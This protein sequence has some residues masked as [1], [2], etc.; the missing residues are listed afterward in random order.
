MS[1]QHVDRVKALFDRVVELPPDRRAAFLEGACAGDQALRVEVQRLLAYDAGFSGGVGG[2]GR[3][4]SPLVR[5]AGPAAVPADGPAPAA[6]PPGG[7]IR[8]GHYRIV[9]R[10]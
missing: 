9:R 8:V 5:T 4:Q 6:G 1:E 2:E 7:P 3:L 10:L